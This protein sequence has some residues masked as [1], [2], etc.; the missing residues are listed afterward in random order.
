VA[1]LVA[2]ERGDTQKGEGARA[3]SGGERVRQPPDGRA[4]EGEG[5]GEQDQPGQCRQLPG[6]RRAD[7]YDGQGEPGHQRCKQRIRPDPG[8]AGGTPAGDGQQRA[9]PPAGRQDLV[10]AGRAG[11]AGRL[12]GF[13]AAGED[14]GA[15]PRAGDQAGGGS[16]DDPWQCHRVCPPPRARVPVRPQQLAR[17]DSSARLMSLKLDVRT[18]IGFKRLLQHLPRHPV[19]GTDRTRPTGMR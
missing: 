14:A 15:Y 12:A 8:A 17:A 19:R 5:N 4:D 16:G 18:K 9:P 6:R 7:G 1:R 13:G 2:G 3:G 11:A 10:A